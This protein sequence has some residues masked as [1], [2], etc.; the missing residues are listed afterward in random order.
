MIVCKF[1]YL[2]L[3]FNPKQKEVFCTKEMKSLVEQVQMTCQS[4]GGE[5]GR[6]DRLLIEE[7]LHIK[8]VTVCSPLK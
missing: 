8:D 2:Q 4:L 3:F 1:A 7:I 5:G 6:G